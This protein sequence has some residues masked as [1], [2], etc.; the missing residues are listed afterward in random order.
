MIRLD[1][2][3][4]QT[5]ESTAKILGGASDRGSETDSL[6][7]RVRKQPFSVVLLDEFEKAHP[8][9]WDLFLQVFDDGRLTDSMGQVADFRHCIVIMTTNLGAT[10]HRTSGLGFARSEDTFTSD[11]ILRAVGQTFRPEFQN[12]HRQDHRVPALTRELMRGILKKEL[13]GLL[14]RRGFKDREWAVEWE[15]S[16]LEFLLEKGFT[17]EMGARPLKRAID[18][19]VLAPIAATIVERR[20][21]EG[22]SVRFRAQ[23]RQEHSGGIRRSD[24][25]VDTPAQSAPAPDTHAEG[26][27]PSLASVILSADGTAEE[28]M[29]IAAGLQEVETTLASEAWETLQNDGLER[30]REPDFWSQP[31][32]TR[33][34]ADRADGS[35]QGG[36]GDGLFL[37][38]ATGQGQ[39]ARGQVVAR[40]DPAPGP[41]DPPRQGRHRRCGRRIAHRGSCGGGAGAL[42]SRPWRRRRHG[43]VRP[44]ARHVS[45]LGKGAEHAGDR[46]GKPGTAPP[47][48]AA[49]QRLRR[50]SRPGGGDG[51]ARFRARDGA[52]TDRTTARVRVVP[53][54]LGDLPPDRLKTQIKARL[55]GL[56]P[57]LRS[58]GAIAPSHLPLVRQVTGT[59]WRSGKL[60]AYSPATSTLSR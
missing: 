10:S 56:L 58:Y 31:R 19:Y 39:R 57:T 25:D 38:G 12:P 37:A 6:V 55:D 16:A 54:P 2:S 41:S 45:R 21:P 48:V 23:R 28:Q 20:F 35:C 30:M 26:V 5:P 47:A 33:P 40:I 17:P 24:M 51:A 60:D 7:L 44:S 52:A 32:R 1:M 4:F 46:G 14:E 42:A 34:R 50:A 9:V 3:E 8:N 13:A 22:G 53:V 49:R 36:Y 18:Q 27:L 29:A 59:P 15:A 11:Q 43:V